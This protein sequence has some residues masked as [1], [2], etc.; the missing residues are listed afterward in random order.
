MTSKKKAILVVSFGT[1]YN[2]TR[3]ATIGAVEQTIARTFPE[4]EI[5]RAFT[6]QKIINKLKNRDGEVIDN[7]KEAMERLEAEGVETVIVQPTHVMNGY[8]HEDMT[9]E[10]ALYQDHFEMFGCGKPLLSDER[11]YENMVNILTEET[12]G[13]RAEKT[14]IVYMGHGTGHEAN[15]VY[16]KLEHKLRAAGFS[17]YY[18]GTVEGTPALEEVIEVIGRGH[19]NHV[20]LLPLMIVAGDHACNDMAGDDKDSWKMA[21]T[22][23]GYQVTCILKGIGEYP[24]VQSMFA[25]HVRDALKASEIKMM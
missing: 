13:Y 21:F 1:S 24:G 5:R 22:A 19:Y 17:D 6:S 7:V 11:D 14:A 12:A 4:Y 2:R 10:V 20:V 16:A 15:V 3:E 25:E 8:E 23:A 9:E 18:I